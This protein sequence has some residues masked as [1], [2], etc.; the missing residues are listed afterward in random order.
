MTSAL[1]PLSEQNEGPT[2]LRLEPRL[3]LLKSGHVEIIAPTL[4]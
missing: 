3:G 1:T 4:A 2:V